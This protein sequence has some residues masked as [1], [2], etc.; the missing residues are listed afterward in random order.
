MPLEGTHGNRHRHFCGL[1]YIIFNQYYRGEKLNAVRTSYV[2]HLML[3]QRPPLKPFGFVYGAG[4]PPYVRYHQN[5]GRK[6]LPDHSCSEV[7]IG[8]SKG[9]L[10]DSRINSVL[11]FF[12]DRDLRRGKKM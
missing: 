3:V 1:M 2:S 6:E 10:Q 7:C 5:G 8:L 11:R 4:P 9:I 12:I